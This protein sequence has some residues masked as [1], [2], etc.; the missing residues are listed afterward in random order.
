MAARR[1]LVALLQLAHAGELAAALAY[2]GHWKATRDCAE[3]AAIRRI[4]DDEWDHRATLRSMLARLGARPVW[5]RE[6]R[7]RTI[8]NVLGA[9]CRVA[10]RW[11]P[12]AAARWLEARNVGE[13]E[14]AAALARAAG[15]PELIVPL[16][17]MA[18]IEA[19]HERF[20]A[21]AIAGQTRA[22]VA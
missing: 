4:E 8:G 15:R 1:A 13:Y 22:E 11:L 18:E 16:F 20:F 6:L 19:E 5:W 14:R 17:R 7:A 9:L 21:R 10:G 3:R 12:L 2:R